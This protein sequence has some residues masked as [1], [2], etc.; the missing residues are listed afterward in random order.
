MEKLQTR[1]GHLVLPPMPPDD[2]KPVVRLDVTEINK[3]LD[4]AKHLLES[5]DPHAA[6]TLLSHVLTAVSAYHYNEP[7]VKLVFDLTGRAA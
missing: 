6:H 3:S 5:G 4:R 7:K 1:Q 2:G